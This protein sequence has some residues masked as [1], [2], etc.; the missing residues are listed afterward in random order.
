MARLAGDGGLGEETRRY[1]GGGGTVVSPPH[2]P[3]VAVRSRRGI[4]RRS[5]RATEFALAFVALVALAPLLAV[6]ALL[7]RVTSPGPVLF[8]QTRVGADGRL[9]TMFKFRSMRAGAEHERDRLRHLNEAVGPLFKIRRDPRLTSV[10]RWMRRF[11]LDELP[12]LLNVLD[13]TMALVGPR[14]VLPEEARTFTATEHRRHAVHPGLTGLAQVSGRSELSWDDVVALDLHYVEHWSLWL[15]VRIVVRT[16]GAVL[17]G[18]GA[19]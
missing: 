1:A 7:V 15:D 4:G 13:G 5:K 10:G 17:F 11:S 9:F 14:P 8:R 3:E 12:Q 18:R 6:L 16:L 2:P 19:Y